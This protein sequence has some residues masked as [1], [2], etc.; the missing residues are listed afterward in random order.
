MWA[1]QSID[2][3]NCTVKPTSTVQYMLYGEYWV[4]KLYIKTV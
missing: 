4:L 2:N 1:K 3:Q